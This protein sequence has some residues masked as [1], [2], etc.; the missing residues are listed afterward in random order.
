M[1]LTTDGKVNIDDIIKI[2]LKEFEDLKERKE[3]DRY[4]IN[5]KEID[6]TPTIELILFHDDPSIRKLNINFIIRY[7]ESV[8]EP[9]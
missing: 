1:N 4:S 8:N 2:L 7:D 9:Q 6:N 5:V 3:I